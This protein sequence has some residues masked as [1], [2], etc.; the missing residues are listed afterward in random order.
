M[1]C[2]RLEKGL[3]KG[4]A[5]DNLVKHHNF[6]PMWLFK[7]IANRSQERPTLTD[8][9]SLIPQVTVAGGGLLPGQ[10]FG[11]SVSFPER[12][13]QKKWNLNK[14]SLNKISGNIIEPTLLAGDLIM[15]DRSRNSIVS[16]GGINAITIDDDIMIKR[17]QTVFPTNYL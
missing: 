2:Y 1:S 5:I 7:A 9:F 10:F 16:R 3:L 17:D 11:F 4:E 8:E 15:V 12:L 14:M 6:N 13:D